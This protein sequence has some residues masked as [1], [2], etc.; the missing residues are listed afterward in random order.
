MPIIQYTQILI[1][2]TVRFYFYVILANT[3]LISY[4]YIIL[5]DAALEIEKDKKMQETVGQRKYCT[6]I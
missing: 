2:F 6:S 1:K 4:F 5:L 3:D